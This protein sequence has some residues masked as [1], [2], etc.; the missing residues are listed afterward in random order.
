MEANENT[1]MD[2]SSQTGGGLVRPSA[3]VVDQTT[4]NDAARILPSS[5]NCL[6]N[7]AVGAQP[8]P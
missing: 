8:Q 2:P 6:P 1:W 5:A 4:S 3:G 7:T